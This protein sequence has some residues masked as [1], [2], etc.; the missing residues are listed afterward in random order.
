MP[1]AFPPLQLALDEVAREAVV[2]GR[3]PRRVAGHVVA[4]HRA[5][6][7][8]DEDDMR[9]RGPVV[10]ARFGLRDGL[11]SVE[12]PRRDLV[13]HRL[14]RDIHDALVR[15]APALLAAAPGV[16]GHLLAVLDRRLELAALDAA[17]GPA[18]AAVRVR[19]QCHGG[20]AQLVRVVSL[21]QT[22]AVL[23][24]SAEGPPEN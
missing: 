22:L 24:R 5:R 21:I 11:A 12:A 19:D 23:S 17:L 8:D 20:G 16:R 9:A 6:M 15:E 4:A 18:L 7:V 1:S 10:V 13:P 14:V 2:H 3:R